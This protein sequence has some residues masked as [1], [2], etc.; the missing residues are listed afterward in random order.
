MKTNTKYISL[1]S[2]TRYIIYIYYKYRKCNDKY[3][4]MLLGLIM[5]KII[6]LLLRKL[7]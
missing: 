3:Y 7:N 4:Y 2:L 5:Y 6:D 1:K